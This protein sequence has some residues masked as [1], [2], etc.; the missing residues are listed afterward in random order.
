MEQTNIRHLLLFFFFAPEPYGPVV[1]HLPQTRFF[2][3]WFLPA[4][5]PAQLHTSTSRRDI[6]IVVVLVPCTDFTALALGPIK[7][8]NTGEGGRGADSHLAGARAKLFLLQ[9]LIRQTLIK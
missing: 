4:G 1:E 8:L 7:A 9:L 3:H 5:D 6:V 2:L